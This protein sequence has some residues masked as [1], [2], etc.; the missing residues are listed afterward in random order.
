MARPKTSDPK[1]NGVIYFRSSDYE[2]CVEAAAGSSFSEWAGNVLIREAGRLKGE[3]PEPGGECAGCRKTPAFLYAP[4]FRQYFCTS[5]IPSGV[6]L[7]DHSNLVK[8]SLPEALQR[9]QRAYAA[10][11]EAIERESPKKPKSNLPAEVLRELS[12]SGQG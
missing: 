2:L 6:S 4:A 3:V 1:V 7:V 5:C 9:F 8:T 11:L 12:K 10:L